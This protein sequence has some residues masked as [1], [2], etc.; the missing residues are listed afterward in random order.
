[1]QRIVKSIRAVVPGNFVVGIKINSDDYVKSS[2]KT[3]IGLVTQ[4][5][6][7]LEHIQEMVNWNSL[8]FIEISGGDYENPGNTTKLRDDC[9]LIY[10]LLQTLCPRVH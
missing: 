6:R 8:D 5:R 2:L 9:L 10:S 1:M 4:E 3:E 7:A